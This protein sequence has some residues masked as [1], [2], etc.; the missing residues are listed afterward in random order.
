MF[1]LWLQWVKLQQP[2]KSRI[3]GVKWVV[4]PDSFSKWTHDEIAV[5]LILPCDFSVSI[6][7][8]MLCKLTAMQHVYQL[9]FL[10]FNQRRV[11]K[12][13]SPR[14]MGNFIL[15][16]LS[17]KLCKVI[18]NKKHCKASAK[19][20]NTDYLHYKWQL[21][22]KQCMHLEVAQSSSNE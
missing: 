3:A 10:P 7:M 16:E 6:I 21:I 19:A 4:R 13:S 8:T 15:I 5:Y 18:A 14:L 11:Q 22:H 1:D 2:V 17:N 20:D 12:S 9:A